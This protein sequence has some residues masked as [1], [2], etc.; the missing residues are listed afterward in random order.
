MQIEASVHAKILPTNMVK[1]KTVVLKPRFD[2][3]IIK[4]VAEMKK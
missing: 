1:R 2:R 3:N 4:L